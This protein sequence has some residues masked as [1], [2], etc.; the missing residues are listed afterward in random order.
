MISI[1]FIVSY[2]YYISTRSLYSIHIYYTVYRSKT[3]ILRTIE[4]DLKKKP[5]GCKDVI[6]IRTDMKISLQSIWIAILVLCRV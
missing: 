5:Y 1:T 3:A 2:R 6:F 4:I